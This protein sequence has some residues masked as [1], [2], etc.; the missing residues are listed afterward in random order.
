[1]VQL[2][3]SSRFALGLS[4]D[5]ISSR[6][7]GIA[8]PGSIF[9]FFSPNASQLSFLVRAM[10]PYLSALIRFIASRMECLKRMLPLLQPFTKSLANVLLHI[11]SLCYAW[12]V[13]VASTSTSPPEFILYDNLAIDSE[14]AR[15]LSEENWRLKKEVLELWSSMK[16]EKPP[17]PQAAAGLGQAQPQFFHHNHVEA[18]HEKALHLLSVQELTGIILYP[19]AVNRRPSQP[20]DWQDGN[21]DKFNIEAAE[22]LANEAL[23]L[24][25][26]DS[27]PIYEKLLATFPTS[28]KYWKQYVE[29]LMAANNDEAA[30]QVFSRCLLICSQVPLWRCYIRFI[31]KIND[32]KGIEGQEETKKAYEFMLNYVGADIASGPVWM[33]YIAYLKSLPAQTTQGESQRMT[34]IRKTYQRAIVMPTHHVEQLWRD[35]ENFENSVSRALA[36]GL[37]AE[38]Q[39]KYNSARAVY[40]ERKKYVDE[41]DWNML[42]IPPSG[43][44]K[45][46]MQW[47]AWK[48]FLN[49]EKGNPQ[50]IDNAS[51]NK[52]IAFAYEQC[53]MYLYHYPDI[54]Y[55]YATWHAKGGSRDSAIKV[56]QRALKALPDSEMLRYAYAE[57]EESHG[58]AQAAKKVYESLVGDGV[59]ATALSHI[60]FIRFLRRTEGVEAAR[61]YFLDARKSPNCTYHVYVAYA[62]MAFCIDKDAKLAHNIFEAGLKR[63]MH[64]PSY[65][66]EYADFLCRLNDDRNIRALFERALSSLPPDE[67]VEVWNRFSQFE[68]TYG[69]LASILKVEQ[70]RKEALCRTAENGESALDNSLQ[71]VISR[72]SFMDLWPCSPKDLDHLARQ[73]L[74]QCLETK[75]PPAPGISIVPNALPNGVTVNS[76]GGTTAINDVLKAL[77]PS[78]ATFVVNLPPIEGPSPD[79]DF[80]ISICLQSNIASVNGT[81]QQLQ[82]GPAPSTSDVSGS[83]KFK[84]TRDRQPGKRKDSQRQEEDDTTTVQSQ[85]LPRDAFKMRQLQKARATTSSRAGTGTGTGGGGSASY[86]SGFSGDLSGSSS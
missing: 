80:V 52:R 75:S 16:M 19:T 74:G 29:A 21:A 44:P 13:V 86:G 12:T 58:A 25:I 36:K 30:R 40:R 28:A 79:V 35:Y 33:E 26:S 73:Q 55:D 17:P 22:I 69:D 9:L 38:Y 50:R 1:M 10:F 54:W 34:S 27:V 14:F 61:K 59:N 43:S 83:S 15:R 57:L 56:F 37:V 51:A 3:S 72:Y 8:A 82:A 23:R 85:P 60:Q 53:L 78:V 76:G 39:P 24:S 48:K 65:I 32:M 77:P 84:Q 67:S 6:S 62:M 41:I 47:M 4:I 81:P 5:W 31:R 11:H 18:V 2:L 7:T 46:E 49:F 20:A 64:E 42:A 63:F 71:D 70:R 68:Q 66:L 45:E